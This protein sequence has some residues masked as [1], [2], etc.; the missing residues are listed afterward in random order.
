MDACKVKAG[1]QNIN[2]MRSLVIYPTRLDNTRPPGNKRSGNTSFV[3]IFF[4]PP[5]RS[6]THVSPGSLI[7][8][9]GFHTTRR[10]RFLND[11]LPVFYIIRTPSIVGKEKDQGIFILF[12]LF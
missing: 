8:I 6:I 12:N 11:L 9:Y 7:T 1:R 2:N 5:E 10:S 3:G 4:E